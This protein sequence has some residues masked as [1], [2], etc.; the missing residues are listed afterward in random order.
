MMILW[1]PF[2]FLIPFVMFWMM[3]SGTGMGSCGMSHA[4][5]AQPPTASGPDPIE[6]VRQRLARGEITTSEYE[7]I[8]R[9]IG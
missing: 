4:G 1:L 3:R 7:A 9:V 2:L 5:N 6:I 8:R